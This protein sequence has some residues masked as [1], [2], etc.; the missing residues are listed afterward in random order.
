MKKTKLRTRFFLTYIVLA[1]TLVLL[2]SVFF[3]SYTSKILVERETQNI[4]NLVTGFQNQTDD[5]V[6][7]L[8]TVS[9]NVG[10]SNLIKQKLEQYF[11]QDSINWTNTSTLAEL[12]V[13]IN[14]TDTRADQINIYDFNGNIIG[15][16]R[17]TIM[18]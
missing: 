16:G 17:A 2:F 18:S 6:R 10:Y 15:F 3:F 11:E 7:A 14:G 9:I 13:A 12:F 1:L 5:A 8:D 4:V